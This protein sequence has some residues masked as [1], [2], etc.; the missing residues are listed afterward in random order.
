LL[1]NV[2]KNF[3]LKN[4]LSSKK[5]IKTFSKAP[6]YFS[7]IAYQGFK[8]IENLDIKLIT[9]GKY[10]LIT[11]IAFPKSIEEYLQTHEIY[12]EHKSYR[13]H[14]NFSKNEI[15]EIAK[16]STK[17]DGIITTEK[18]WMR[19]RES[20]LQEQTKSTIYRLQIEIELLHSDKQFMKQLNKIN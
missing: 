14:N 20:N 2:P 13:D 3:V 7:C 18:D 5:K 1:Q 17:F 9:N 12:F 10:L 6:V 8:S 4:K 15:K 11:S 19:L 16:K